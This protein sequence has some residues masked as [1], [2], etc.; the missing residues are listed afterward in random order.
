MNA[1][2]ASITYGMVSEV[3]NLKPCL[4][5]NRTY[6]HDFS[7]N[8]SGARKKEPPYTKLSARESLASMNAR[9]A[10]NTYEMV[11][12]V[13]NLYATVCT[14]HILTTS[15]CLLNGATFH[16][17]S[18]LQLR[19]C[20]KKLI[21]LFPNQNICCG[22]SKALKTYVQTDGLENNYNFTLKNV[23]YLNLCQNLV[24]QPICQ[25]NM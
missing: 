2:F 13:D 21:F 9:L 12:E 14:F 10:S 5:I 4:L 19:V 24:Q 25:S 1:K 18:A 6:L 3:H 22:Y 8:V 23:V 15:N 20:T 17:V 7:N 11:S 16:S